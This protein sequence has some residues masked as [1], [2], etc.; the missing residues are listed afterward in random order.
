VLRTGWPPINNPF[1][2]ITTDRTEAD[3][4]PSQNKQTN[5]SPWKER[6]TAHTAT[7]TRRVRCGPDRPKEAQ[8]VTRSPEPRDRDRPCHLRF[9]Y[10]PPGGWHDFDT[11]DSEWILLPLS[12][13]CTVAVRGRT[14]LLPGRKSLFVGAT[15]FV[16]TPR[17]AHVA[18]AT[19]NGGS[20]ALTGGRCDRRL[21]ARH[22]P[23]SAVPLELHSNGHYSRRLTDT[24]GSGVLECD[25]LIATEVLM[26][27]GTWSF[28]LSREHPEDR[29]GEDR[30]VLPSRDDSTTDCPAGLRDG[31]IGLGRDR[32]QGSPSSP[33]PAPAHRTR[34]PPRPC[35]SPAARKETR[36]R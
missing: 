11:G 18:V 14:F 21:P 5:A 31:G 32:R 26:P 4:Y 33:P 2:A 15:D 29:R 30:L 36:T 27:G 25:G 1:D 34:Q 24:V 28:S 20:F 22:Q 7:D 16:Y 12:G 9:L 13:S 10:L 35:P 8:P 23:A 6:H 3:A 19:R 17:D